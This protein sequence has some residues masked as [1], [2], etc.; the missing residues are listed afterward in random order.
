MLPRTPLE[1]AKIAPKHPSVQTLIGSWDSKILQVTEQI[2]RDE[3]AVVPSVFTH[4]QQETWM[5]KV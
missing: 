2:Y 1:T 5:R 4:M 3:H